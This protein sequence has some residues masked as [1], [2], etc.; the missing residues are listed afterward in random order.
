MFVP[1]DSPASRKE[2]TERILRTLEEGRNL[3]LYPEGGIKGK[4][5]HYR[6]RHGVF[7]ISLKTGIPV[8]PVFIH[9]EAQDDFHWSNQTLPRKILEL[10]MA[11]NKR[12]NY[13][14]F[15]VFRPED[16]SDKES[17]GQAV[18]QRYLSWQKKYLE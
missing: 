11:R 17:F 16:F 4:R 8:L 13:L 2:A 6:F 10:M 12:A 15:D 7:S 1:R 3:A 18:Y 9:Y 14:V 5:L